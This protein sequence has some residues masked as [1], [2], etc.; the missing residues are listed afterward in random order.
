MSGFVGPSS[1]GDMSNSVSEPKEDYGRLR[2]AQ[3]LV[4]P[5]I[6]LSRV[7]D[8]SSRNKGSEEIVPVQ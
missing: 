7:L 1:C 5:K 6:P 4:L 2:N 8:R 3:H